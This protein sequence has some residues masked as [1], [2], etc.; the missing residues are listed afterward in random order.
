VVATCRVREKRSLRWWAAG[1][2]RSSRGGGIPAKPETEC[3]ARGINLASKLSAGSV[4]ATCWVKGK[5]SLKW[6]EAESER[7][8]GRRGI[9]MPNRK[10]S[11]PL[12]VSVWYRNNWRAAW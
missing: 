5:R 12:S 2:G 7:S 9:P 8:S 1:T 3:G 4:V 6:W 10:P 11:V